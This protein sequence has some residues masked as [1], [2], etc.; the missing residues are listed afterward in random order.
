MIVPLG[1]Q[2]SAALVEHLVRRAALYAIHCVLRILIRMRILRILFG[3]LCI[4]GIRSHCVLNAYR[5]QGK[6]CV[7][8]E[9]KSA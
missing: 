9:A 7:S 5:D 3:H 6:K 8:R 1:F 2:I 4:A